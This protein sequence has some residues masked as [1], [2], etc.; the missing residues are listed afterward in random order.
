MCISLGRQIVFGT[1]LQLNKF[2]EENHAYF[3][4]IINIIELGANFDS[5]GLGDSS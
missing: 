1:L 4:P 5:Y 2:P 3:I